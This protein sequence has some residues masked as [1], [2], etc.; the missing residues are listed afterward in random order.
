MQQINLYDQRT[1]YLSHKVEKQIKVSTK[2]MEFIL[3]A[4][5]VVYNSLNKGL[6]GEYVQF[7]GTTTKECVLLSNAV[8]KPYNFDLY[9]R[10]LLENVLDANLENYFSNS[11]TK[12]KSKVN[13]LN[14]SIAIPSICN[15][16]IY[17][18]YILFANTENDTVLHLNY[19]TFKILEYSNNILHI[20]SKDIDFTCSSD[21]IYILFH[22]LYYKKFDKQLIVN[23]PE[24]KKAERDLVK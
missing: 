2:D 3:N 20:R 10:I 12:F 6:Y 5:F 14:S 22:Q 9:Q 18:N 19:D 8:Y 16:E 21:D 23:F 11:S 13:I 4:T 17:D 24:V 1:G 7:Q 15:V